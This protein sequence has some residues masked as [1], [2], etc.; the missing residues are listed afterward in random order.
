MADYQS[1]LED[2]EKRGICVYALSTDSEE[3]ARATVEKL[4]VTFPVLHGVDGLALS[5]AWGSYYEER[6]A[7]LHATGFIVGPDTTIL[8][9]TYSTGPVGRLRAVDA[10]GFI[11]FHKSRS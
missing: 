11:T 5:K 8:S 2:L 6:R 9:A 7:I 1:N 10:L 4:G 3:H